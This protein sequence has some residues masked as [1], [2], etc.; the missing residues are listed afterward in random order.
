MSTPGY[1][2]DTNGTG[3]S[4]AGADGW[5]GND[6]VDNGG[7]GLINWYGFD[8]SA[9]ETSGGHH[10]HLATQNS[11]GND[12]PNGGYLRVTDYAA[13]WSG[14]FDKFNKPCPEPIGEPNGI[15]VAQPISSSLFA[16]IGSALI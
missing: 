1:V 9:D 12:L 14:I 13:A 8:Q 7:Y 10:I 2:V 6:T 15:T 11:V 16:R 4:T 3:N 5:G